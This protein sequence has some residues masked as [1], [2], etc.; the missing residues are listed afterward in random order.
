MWITRRRSLEWIRSGDWL[1][2][3]SLSS[4]RRWRRSKNV[5]KQLAGIQKMAVSTTTVTVQSMSLHDGQYDN[6]IPISILTDDIISQKLQ[7][8]VDVNLFDNVPEPFHRVL[9]RFLANALQPDERTINDH[10]SFNSQIPH[11]PYCRI[12]GCT[13]SHPTARP[14]TPQQSTSR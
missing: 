9:D 7:H 13:A 12:P 8:L 3:S 4:S 14:T 5:I 2:C 10:H 6:I 11:S 1:H